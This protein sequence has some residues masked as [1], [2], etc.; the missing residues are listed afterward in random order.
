MLTFSLQLLKLTFLLNVLFKI[1]VWNL[2]G[3]TINYFLLNHN[4]ADSDS[5]SKISISCC[6][7]LQVAKIVFWSEKLWS[8]DLF[9]QKIGHSGM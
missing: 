5:C 1:M 3:L 8:S 7:L 2:L 6:K 9:S 4:T